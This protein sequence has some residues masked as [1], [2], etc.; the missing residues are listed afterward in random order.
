MCYWMLLCTL[1][2]CSH[3][4]TPYA[5]GAAITV[6]TGAKS[7]YGSRLAECLGN[8]MWLGRTDMKCLEGRKDGSEAGRSWMGEEPLC[9]TT[10]STNVVTLPM[11]AAA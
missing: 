3:C 9:C 6:A 5:N 8:C 7:G 1:R 10:L 2:W 11:A 4:T